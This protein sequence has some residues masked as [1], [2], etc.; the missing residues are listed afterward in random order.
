MVRRADLSGQVALVTGASRGLGLLIARELAGRGARLVICARNGEEL[1]AT[2][3]RL[4]AEGAEVLAVECDLADR[5]EAERLVDRAA[6]HFGR[7]DIVVNNAGIMQVGP[8]P[9]VSADDF[10][11]AVQIML[12]GPV[13]VTLR[14]LPHLRAAPVGRIVNITSIGGKIAVP[15]ML[16]YGCGKFGLVGFSEGLRAELAGEGIRVTTVVPG[17]MRTGSHLRA[18]FAGQAAKEYSWFAA[19]ASAP[20]LSMDAQRAARRVVDAAVAGRGSLTLTLPAVVATRLAGLAPGLDRSLG[21]GGRAAAAGRA[22]PAGAGR[23]GHLVAAESP[24]RARSAMT[25]LGRR[26]AER[27]QPTV[28]SRR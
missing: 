18:L 2:Q 24:S 8:L 5:S 1:R 11:A 23:A 6:S 15:H 27:F 28:G 13:H 12:M 4:R 14:A 10:E 17:L 21:R 16:P 25:T 19:A 26:A 20:L 22:G 9:A 3:E 7:L